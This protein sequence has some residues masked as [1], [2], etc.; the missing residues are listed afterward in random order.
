MIVLLLLVGLSGFGIWKWKFENK[1]EDITADL[2]LHEVSKGPFDHIVLDQGELESS[3]NI[4]ILC[5]VKAKGGG[6]TPILWV[7]EEGTAVKKGDMV[8]RLDKSA[9]ED[10]LQIQKIAVNGAIAKLISSK[11]LLETSNIA[12]TEYLEGTYQTEESSLLGEIALAKQELR[13]SQLASAS[14]ERLVAKGSIK[15]LQQEADQYAV[16]NSQGTLDSALARLKVLR[17]LTQKKMLVQFDSEIEKAKALVNSDQSILDEEQGKQADLEKQIEACDMR[18]PADGICV[19]SNRYS[20]RGGSAE[21]VVEAG[22]VVREQ[23]SIVRL[24]DPTKMQVKAK[25]SEGN[26]TLV[27]EGMPVK[28]GVDAITN[29]ELLGRVTKV[30]RYAEPSSFF[31][32]QIKEYAVFIQIIN[33]PSE[34]RTGMTAEVRIFVDQRPDAIQVPVHG[35]YEHGNKTYC[36]V[37]K[38]LQFE[39]RAVSV[40]ATNDTSVAIGEGLQVGDTIVLN[41][42]KHLDLMDLPETTKGEA[43]SK[44]LSEIV[45]AQGGPMPA[46]ADGEKKGEGRGEGSKGK[47]RKGTDGGGGGGSGGFNPA[48]AV[49]RTFEEYD[50]DKDGKL[51]AEELNRMPEERRSRAILADINGD[52]SITRQEMTT[53]M[54]RF[55]GGGRPGGGGGPYG[56]GGPAG[57][58]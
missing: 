31:S 3:S 51:N 12:R 7:L 4:E 43:D 37:K 57:G 22:A 20:S 44:S 19:Y 30:N 10:Q 58:N 52:G 29:M 6:G 42:R 11:A 34:I 33:P 24:P 13:K 40:S 39:T 28:I 46:K 5:Q 47:N 2:I 23:Q 8:V 16:E 35:L 41:P 21:F 32:S 18:A 50:G 38:G 49:A 17:E 36:L 1:V 14:S 45:A 25:I 56:G 54:Q 9:L 53:A 26:I 48:Q 15:S 55:S 27:Q